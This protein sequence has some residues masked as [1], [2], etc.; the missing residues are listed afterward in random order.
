[1]RLLITS[2]G[3]Y[4]PEFVKGS[5]VWGFGSEVAKE[6]LG[7]HDVLLIRSEDSRSPFFKAVDNLVE[8]N[9]ETYLNDLVSH[10][11]WCEIHR[12]QFQELTYVT[13]E[14]LVLDQ[15][16][17]H[18]PDVIILGDEMDHHFL[19]QIDREILGSLRKI[20][21]AKDF[22]SDK[23]GQCSLNL[24][25]NTYREAG[26]HYSGNKLVGPIDKLIK[27]IIYQATFFYRETHIVGVG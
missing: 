13:Q 1:M 26:V 20:V 8:S 27:S 2:G 21:A 7:G 16:G 25:I 4:G 6:A 10:W 14:K 5:V 23:N 19:S 17:C 18:H 12:K 3:M 22:S 11:N 9:W 24:L 15:I